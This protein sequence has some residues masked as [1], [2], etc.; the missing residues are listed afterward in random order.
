[1][2][3][4]AT[5]ASEMVNANGRIYTIVWSRWEPKR[6]KGFALILHHFLIIH[7]IKCFSFWSYDN[8]GVTD[9][10]SSDLNQ[11]GEQIGIHLFKIFSHT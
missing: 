6:E 11:W 7:Q 10:G 4:T 5:S 2:T 1:M 3:V 9:C 8:R